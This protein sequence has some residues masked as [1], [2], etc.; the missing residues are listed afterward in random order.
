MGYFKDL[1]D[2]KYRLFVEA[3]TDKKG[4]RKRRTRIVRASGVREVRKLLIA[5]ENEV[6]NEKEVLDQITF[7]DFVEQWKNAYAIPNLSPSTRE[8]YYG[9]L[10]YFIPIFKDEVMTEIKTID[11]VDFFAQEILNNKK[12]L[13]KKYNVM[14]SL[15]T[16]ATRWNVLESNPM[17]GVSKPKIKRKKR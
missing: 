1:G 5:F 16:H 4:N 12:Q 10:D 14:L 13:E 11:L 2:N 6:D 3:G 9:I 7:G 15:F 8:V 17:I